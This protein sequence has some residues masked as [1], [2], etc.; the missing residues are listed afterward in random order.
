MKVTDTYKELELML[1]FYELRHE[2]QLRGARDWYLDSFYP[3]S[4]DEIKRKYRGGDAEK[5]IVMVL[6]Y[7]EMVASILNRGLMD[8]EM[9]FENNGEMWVVWD[10]IRQFAPA[11]R[12]SHKNPHLFRNLEDACKR[13][14]DSREQNSPGST[15]ILRRM[16]NDQKNS[17]TKD[18]GQ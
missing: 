5:S 6:N 7:W 2:P 15:M 10:R 3:T 18:D 1:R 17:G 8:E 13:F 4:I 16:I 11:W 14:E 9:F 12:S